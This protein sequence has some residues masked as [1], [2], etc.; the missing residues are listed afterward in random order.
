MKPALEFAFRIAINS[1][2]PTNFMSIKI[3]DSRLKI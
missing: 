2:K 1:N 3:V